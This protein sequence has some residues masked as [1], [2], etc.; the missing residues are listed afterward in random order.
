MQF[1]I[2]LWLWAGHSFPAA[3]SWRLPRCMRNW[4]TTFA[5]CLIELRIIF[6]PCLNHSLSSLQRG[7]MR[8]GVTS[9]VVG[10]F[11]FLTNLSQTKKKS[12]TAEWNNNIAELDL[13]SSPKLLIT[14]NP[15]VFQN[16]SSCTSYFSN[17]PYAHDDSGS[18]KEEA[19]FL[20]SWQHYGSS[21]EGKDSTYIINTIWLAQ[22][23]S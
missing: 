10:Y 7:G 8:H 13:V 20:S 15:F 1:K 19:P 22:N 18:R 5:V 3:V 14:R 4:A 23:R 12:I 21:G 17:A 9:T 16:S 2:A 11:P 6:E